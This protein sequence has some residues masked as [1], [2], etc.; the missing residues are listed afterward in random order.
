VRLELSLFPLERSRE[1]NEYKNIPPSRETGEK[2]RHTQSGGSAEHPRRRTK[3]DDADDDRGDDDDAKKP[4]AL[5]AGEGVL[6]LANAAG[7]DNL[8]TV[9]FALE[10]GQERGLDAAMDSKGT[11]RDESRVSP[12]RIL[13]KKM[14]SRTVRRAARKKN[15]TSLLPCLQLPQFPLFHHLSSLSFFHPNNG[16]PSAQRPALHHLRPRRSPPRWGRFCPHAP[17]R[18]PPRRRRARREGEKG[19]RLD[20]AAAAALLSFF[21]FSPFFLLPRR[22]VARFRRRLWFEERDFDVL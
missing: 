9:V 14:K 6:I 2:R 21:G 19:L 10:E 1:E 17:G 4:F 22:F 15:T 18:G 20:A 11:R 13:L 7:D 16:N 5:R 3:S 8:A 12:F